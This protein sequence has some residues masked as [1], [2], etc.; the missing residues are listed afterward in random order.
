MHPALR[1]L[2]RSIRP[3]VVYLV[4]DRT[5]T[6]YLSAPNAELIPILTPPMNRSESML[7]ATLIM[8]IILDRRPVHVDDLR[9]AIRVLLPKLSEWFDSAHT[10]D[11]E[12]SI[13]PPL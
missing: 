10:I 13:P 6:V 3:D 12:R 5:R 9:Q 7:D 2:A 11:I 1:L 8:A 4:H